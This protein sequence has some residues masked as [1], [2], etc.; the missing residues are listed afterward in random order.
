MTEQ[1]KNNLK[2]G[3]ERE[4]WPGRYY[5]DAD[6]D[7]LMHRGHIYKDVL[8]QLFQTGISEEEIKALLEPLGFNPD[9][10]DYD[11][12]VSQAE[13]TFTEEQ[14]DELIAYLE[15]EEGITARKTQ[16]YKPADGFMGIGA[17]PVGGDTAWI[18]LSD[19]E[20]YSLSFDVWAYYDIRR[21]EYLKPS[22]EVEE[23]QL[24]QRVRM[25]VTRDI[26]SLSLEELD[27]LQ[28]WLDDKKAAERQALIKSIN[29]LI[30]DMTVEALEDIEGYI[31]RIED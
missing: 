29:L 3:Q 17:N 24:K 25:K 26:K 21:A 19:F 30:S 12:V 15:K 14:A 28:D 6:I 4:L 5:V 31:A 7:K 11:Y 22:P 16:A 13:E 8:I 1:D 18:Q 10:E 2:D 23:E 9:M 27:E 20:D